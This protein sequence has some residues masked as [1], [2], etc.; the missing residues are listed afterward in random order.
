[1]KRVLSLAVTVLLLS[2][3][4]P[5]LAGM[6]GLTGQTPEYGVQAAEP[7][8]FV[9]GPHYV[10]RVW[11]GA[12]GLILALSGNTWIGTADV[13]MAGLLANAVKRKVQAV[14]GVEDVDVRIVWDPPWTPDRLSGDAKK[15]LES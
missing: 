10:E 13:T 4:G 14:E 3:A 6:D 2:A 11:L 1:M 7:Q 9:T 12:Q 15:M 8:N 5:A